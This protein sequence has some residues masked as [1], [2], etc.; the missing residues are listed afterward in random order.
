MEV[1]LHSAAGDGLRK[2]SWSEALV[3]YERLMLGTLR[4]VGTGRLGLGFL[5]KE[6]WQET[7]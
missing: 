3:A 2:G 7:I 4:E 1:L 6:H 5:G